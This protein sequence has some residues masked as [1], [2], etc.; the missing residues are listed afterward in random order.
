M[1]GISRIICTASCHNIAQYNKY[2]VSLVKCLLD[3]QHIIELRFVQKIV[4]DLRFELSCTRFDPYKKKKNCD[5]WCFITIIFLIFWIAINILF[6]SIFISYVDEFPFFFLAYREIGQRKC[7]I[8]LLTIQ[9]SM[10]FILAIHWLW[11][12]HE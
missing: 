6:F 11:S 12:I 9:M 8:C 4:S 2:D 5:I 3:G 10:Q 7:F 1:A